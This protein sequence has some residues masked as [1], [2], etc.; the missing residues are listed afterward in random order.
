MASLRAIAEALDRAEKRITARARRSLKP[1]KE[2]A[3][4]DI[5][6]GRFEIYD[7]RDLAKAFAIGML[8]AYVFGKAS[9][10]GELRKGQ[11]TQLQ[12]A[13]SEEDYWAQVL[14]FL[15]RADQKLIVRLIRQKI[16]PFKQYFR[17]S[18]IALNF[19]EGYTLQL[20]HVIQADLL[21]NMT[22]WIRETI[23]QGMSEKE[24]IKYLSSK[25]KQ[26]AE[27]R[28]KM[29]ARTEA[30]RAFNIGTL[31]ETRNSN[32][33]VGYRF[34][35]VLDRRTSDI[36]RARDGKF[37]SKDDLDLLIQNTPPLHVNCRSMLRPITQYE[38]LP[39]QHMPSFFEDKKEQAKQRPY[40][41]AVLRQI[42]S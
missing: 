7:I 13:E 12:L 34:D 18:D 33:I 2:Q 38:E 3:V 16:D 36:C 29:I 26:F 17:P 39:K 4:A 24:A 30:T 6:E 32:I 1:I 11:K 21:K 19:L 22:A 5:L 37:I 8:S 42:L 35:A 40:D 23:M 41:I 20:A 15:V 31:E 14:K 25:T 28:L 27:R 10:I 9:V